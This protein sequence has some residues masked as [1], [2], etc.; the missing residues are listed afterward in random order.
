MRVRKLGAVSLV[1]A[2][3]ALTLGMSGAS[4]KSSDTVTLTME[5]SSTS[6]IA[7]DALISN[8]EAAYPNVKVQP[9]YLPTG[10]LANLI[11]T[12]L[13]AG[14]APDLLYVTPGGQ[15]IGSVWPLAA[16]ARLL[17]LSGQK[18]YKRMGGKQQ[19]QLSSFQG[20]TYAWPLAFIP[21]FV[22]YNTQIFNQLN[23]KVPK[24][25][26]QMLG[27]CK[28]IS[29][30]GKIPFAAGFNDTGTWSIISRMLYEQTVFGVNSNWTA[31][32]TANKTTFAA[33]SGWH[34]ALQRLVDMNNAN[35]FGPG[36][37]G[38]TRPGVYPLFANGQ[39][40]MMMIASSEIPNITA[41]NA[42]VPYSIFNPPFAY[43]P[44]AQV[45][46]VP[47]SVMLAVSKATQH[48]AEA[49]E[50]VNFAARVYQSS[51]FNT[52]GQ[53]IAPYDLQRGIVPSSMGS[54]VPLI[55]KGQYRVGDETYWDNS[56]YQTGLEPAI[57]GL[58]TGQT[59]VSATL[60]N[61]DKLWNSSSP[62]GH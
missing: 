13:Q 34:L 9:T 16:S 35:C 62:P 11:P 53:T 15:K 1:V 22:I 30:A 55:K 43:N 39:A 48:P 52:L 21:D 44:A 32:R 37:A 59:T 19:Q 8:F 45:V 12:Q 56:V 28:T 10:T 25:F 36:A 18:W 40:A 47:A 24:T 41:I 46:A 17:D 61:L 57:Q 42:N 14:T 23:L 7:M 51:N 38:L 49:R 31:Q 20:R 54:L 2:M 27:M 26:A 29:A 5:M 50:F 4:A 60:A 58:I 6:Q 33:T 3:A